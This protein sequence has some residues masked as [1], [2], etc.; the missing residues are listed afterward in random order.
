MSPSS[1]GAPATL[2]LL[3]LASAW[4][5]S[6]ERWNTLPLLA[7]VIGSVGLSDSS[8]VVELLLLEGGL[9]GGSA[10]P[11]ASIMVLRPPRNAFRVPLRLAS[12]GRESN[13]CVV[14]SLRSRRILS[15]SSCTFGRSGLCGF[16]RTCP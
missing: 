9:S 1:S 4:S 7:G 14:V 13:R 16:S 15:L 8:S 11:W 3:K 5:R 12:S 10:L 6:R 2:L